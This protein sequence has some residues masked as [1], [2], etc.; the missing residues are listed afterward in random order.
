MFLTYRN[1]VKCIWSKQN[2]NASPRFQDEWE[3]LNA[4]RRRGVSCLWQRLSKELWVSTTLQ[5]LLVFYT[6]IYY[7]SNPETSK[8]VSLFVTFHSI[9]LIRISPSLCIH[10]LRERW[11]RRFIHFHKECYYLLLSSLLLIKQKCVNYSPHV[12]EIIR[13]LKIQELGK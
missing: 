9:F 8:T 11:K 4:W 10:V 12:F 2:V 5:D 7:L 1:L 6:N 13:L 3:L